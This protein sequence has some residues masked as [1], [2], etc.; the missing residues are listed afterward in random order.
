MGI[1]IKMQDD[2]VQKEQ[3][4]RISWSFGAKDDQILPDIGSIDY[5]VP[6]SLILLDEDIKAIWLE[7]KQIQNE[8]DLVHKEGLNSKVIDDIYASY[9]DSIAGK[10]YM[11]TTAETKFKHIPVCYNCYKFYFK[12]GKQIIGTNG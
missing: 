10:K 2:I 3:H 6:N 8:I 1:I 12:L 4:H 5:C 9:I 11:C 7:Q